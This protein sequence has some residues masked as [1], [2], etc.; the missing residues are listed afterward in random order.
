MDWLHIFVT[1]HKVEFRDFSN[2]VIP[3]FSRESYIDQVFFIMYTAYFKEGD[4]LTIVEAIISSRLHLNKQ[5]NEIN[6]TV[7][8]EQNMRSP[9]CLFSYLEHVDISNNCILLHLLP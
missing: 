7:K 4:L 8:S 3:V 5:I 1:Y 2:F 9:V 6:I